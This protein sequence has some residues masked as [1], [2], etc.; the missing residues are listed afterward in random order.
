MPIDRK[1]YPPDWTETSKRIRFDRAEGRC[2]ECGAVHG[3]PH[4]KTG[5]IVK[6][7]TAHLNRDPQQTRDEELKALCPRCHFAY[8]R[9]DNQAKKAYGRLYKSLTFDLFG[10]KTARLQLRAGCKISSI[11]MYRVHRGASIQKNELGFGSESSDQL[12]LCAPM[13]ASSMYWR[14]IKTF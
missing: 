8:D 10:R 11:K 7:Q 14:M 5:K 4:P 1:A 2:E 12:G 9:A 6:L 3:E 13:D